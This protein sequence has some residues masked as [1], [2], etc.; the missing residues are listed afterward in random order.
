VTDELRD[1]ALRA[2]A[3]VGGGILAVDLLERTDGELLVT[4]VNHT[5]EFHGLSAVA[6][7]DVADLVVAYVDRN[8]PFELEAAA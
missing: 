6:D 2:A 7:V 1:L 8:S 3:A 4:E 5:M